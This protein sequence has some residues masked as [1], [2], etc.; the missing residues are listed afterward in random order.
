MAFSKRKL[1]PPTGSR[2]G[3]TAAVRSHVVRPG[4]GSALCFHDAG[5][6]P[7]REPAVRA[8]RASREGPSTLV[9]AENGCASTTLFVKSASTVERDRYLVLQKAGVP[10]SRLLAE[11]RRDDHLVVVFEFLDA[12]GVDTSDPDEVDELRLVAL[13]NAVDATAAAGLPALARGVRKR[14][15]RSRSDA[16]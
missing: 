7:G 4:S 1:S 5:L 8:S 15:S 12:I 14:S 3:S 11:V 13:L 10:L 6:R 16:L 9:T 2:R